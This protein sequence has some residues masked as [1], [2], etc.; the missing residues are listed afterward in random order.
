MGTLGSTRTAHV[1]SSATNDKTT[2]LFNQYRGQLIRLAKR[3]KIDK[4]SIDVEDLISVG[5]IGLLE[6][7]ASYDEQKNSN[8]WL[9]A[10]PRVRGAMVDE[11]RSARYFGRRVG[12]D[13]S[14]E[15]FL[16]AVHSGVSYMPLVEFGEQTTWVNG[17]ECLKARNRQIVALYFIRGL[18]LHKIGALFDITESRVAQICVRSLNKLRSEA[19]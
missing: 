1:L 18:A 12:L 13:Y 11:I 10:Y 19:P 6:A 15:E 9:Y 3:Q 8:F 17:I 4:A 2:Q 7:S 16:A 14:F 5:L